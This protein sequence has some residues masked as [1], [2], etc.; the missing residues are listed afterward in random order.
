MAHPQAQNGSASAPDAFAAGKPGLM[1]LPLHPSLARAPVAKLT[2]AP[3]AGA[4]A[5]LRTPLGLSKASARAEDQLRV[6]SRYLPPPPSSSA[7]PLALRTPIL[8]S[9]YSWVKPKAR[10]CKSPGTG[11]DQS[12]KARLVLSS[13]VGELKK[14]PFMVRIVKK[15]KPRGGGGGE[16]EKDA[17]QQHQSP[18]GSDGG[19]GGG[20]K[21]QSK[22]GSR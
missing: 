3:E 6:L 4:E 1:P 16:R 2:W 15:R 11:T 10:L 22:R 18:S 14:V 8:E 20:R 5:L 7:F 21:N 12:V 17:K 13:P 9:S 19:D